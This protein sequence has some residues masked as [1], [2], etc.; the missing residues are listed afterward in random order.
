MPTLYALLTGINRYPNPN[1]VLSGCLNDVQHLDDYLKTYCESMGYNYRP[2][3]LRDKQATRQA[4]IDG[5][6]HFQAAEKE[7]F[8]MFHFSGH[9]ARSAAPKAFWDYEPDRMLESLVCWDSRQPGGYDLMDKELSYLVWQAAQKTELPF[10]TILDCCHSGDMRSVE[11]VQQD[12]KLEVVGVRSLR[13]GA[14]AVP[15]AQFLGIEHYKKTNKGQLSPPQGRRVHLGA[16]RDVELAKEVN[17]AGRHCGIFTYCLVEALRSMGPLISYADLLQHVNMRIKSNVKEQSAQ[18]RAAFTEDRNLGVFFS[19]LDAGRPS[20]LLSWSK[21]LNNWALNAGALQ[22]IHE[23][24][25][26]RRTELELVDDNRIVTVVSVLPN[27]SIV[28]GM[29]GYDK[30]RSYVV[31]I[32]R[33]VIPKLKLFISPDSEPEGIRVLRELV[34]KDASDLFHILETEAGCTFMVRAQGGAYFLTQLHND[35]PLFQKV[36]GY[37]SD[38]AKFFLQN[39][40]TVANWQQTLE[41][42]NPDTD[43]QP[44]EITV[45]LYRLTEARDTDEMDDD[46]PMEL[47]YQQSTPMRYTYFKEKNGEPMLPAFQ[48]RVRNTGKRPLWVGLLYLGADFSITDKLLD[49][50]ALEPG[51]AVWATEISNSHQ[52]RTIPLHIHDD[53]RSSVDEYLKMLISTEELSTG[54]YNQDGLEADR[55][56]GPTRLIKERKAPKERD[57]AARTICVRIER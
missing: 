28:S 35:F 42:Y 26:N 40:E 11:E 33:R 36:A 47:V 56:E 29:E 41:L 48:L 3:I 5:F 20:Y 22:G 15:E 12:L 1:H 18:L 8:C 17:A 9:G 34:G 10:L 51:N 43:I 16:C 24:D 4:I 57:W 45:E 44:S 19:R 52:Y 38:S 30:K 6:A 27:C 55:R 13:A 31:I 14:E 53:Q 46:A 21:D 25:A 37:N 50:L 49:N 7:D 54:I 32:K 23:G 2:L 39:L